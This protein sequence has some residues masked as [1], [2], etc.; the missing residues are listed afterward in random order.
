MEAAEEIDS[1]NTLGRALLNWD[2]SLPS[3]KEIVQKFGDQ[4][5]AEEMSKALTAAVREYAAEDR[6]HLRVKFNKALAGKPRKKRG[7]T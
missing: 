2:G 1:P 4:F 6:R 3:A 7:R 5:S